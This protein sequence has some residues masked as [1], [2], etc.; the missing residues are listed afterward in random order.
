MKKITVI[1]ELRGTALIFVRLFVHGR[2]YFLDYDMLISVR[3]EKTG[4]GGNEKLKTIIFL[5]FKE[6]E[7]LVNAK[8]Y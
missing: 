6:N 8:N 1:L 7:T 5:N 2:S 4:G 3:L